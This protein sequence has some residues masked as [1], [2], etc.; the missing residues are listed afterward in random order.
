MKK[1]MTTCLI[2]AMFVLMGMN[3]ADAYVIDPATGWAGWFG[4]EDGLGQMDYILESDLTY[5]PDTEWTMALPTGGTLSFATAYDDFLPD[6]EFALYIDGV[7]KPWDSVTIDASG[8]YHGMIYEENLAPGTHSFTMY[9][10][11]LSPGYQ[12]GDAHAS[13]SAVIIPE[14]ATL[15][16][17]GL[18]VPII[19]RFRRKR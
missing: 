19:S 12:S 10:T 13:F 17:L 3:T 18:G 7:V 1:L 16:L 8:Y 6:D 4:W 2:V 11:A 15:L 9:L 14:P 5:I